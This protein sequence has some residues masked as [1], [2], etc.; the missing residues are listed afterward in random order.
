MSLSQNDTG[1]AFEYG[2]AVS[3]S[4]HLPALIEEG[5]QVRKARACFELCDETEQVHI[6]QAAR[7]VAAFLAAHDDRLSETSCSIRLQSDQVG[8]EGDVRDIV[9][10]NAELNED[11]G[12]SAKNRHLAVKHS[13]LSDRIDFGFH[14]LGVACSASYFDEVRPMFLELHSR[15]R[16]GE[17]WRDIPNKTEQYYVPLLRAFRTEMQLLSQREPG[18]VAGALVKYLLGRFDYYKVI[19]EN[20]A[21]SIM[22]FNTS[23]TLKWGHRLPLPR[24][25][26]EIS[27]KPESNTTL[28]ITFDQGWQISFRI[29]SASTKVEPS[30]KFDINL[31]GL[32]STM[33][34]QVI[35]YR[36][37][38]ST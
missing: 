14:W 34:T 12:I 28:I 29:H 4:D 1:R 26:I 8:R 24:R 33:S 11:I 23:G 25:I 2:V 27:Q 13:R 30:L 5:P 36:V 16:K 19:K 37:R 18:K 6:V 20:S 15:K 32:P 38:A 35:E 22:S 21:V 31:V 7:E 10:H 3:L 9:V 17:R